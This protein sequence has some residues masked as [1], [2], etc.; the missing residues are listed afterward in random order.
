MLYLFFIERILQK[1]NNLLIQYTPCNFIAS[2]TLF[3]IHLDGYE[4]RKLCIVLPSTVHDI[5]FVMRNKKKRKKTVHGYIYGAVVHRLL[6]NCLLLHQLTKAHHRP[7]LNLQFNP[8]LLL[9]WCL[10][11]KKRQKINLPR[12][13]RRRPSL[14]PREKIWVIPISK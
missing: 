5:I 1:K 14:L 11:T 6:W 10:L 12:R 8:I 9:L 2:G 3:S 7:Q 13:Q 4:I